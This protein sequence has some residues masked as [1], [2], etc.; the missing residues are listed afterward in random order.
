MK[1][2][3]TTMF[4]TKVGFEEISE[5]QL[6]LCL[7]DQTILGNVQDIMASL[8]YPIYKSQ[9]RRLQNMIPGCSGSFLAMILLPYEQLLYSLC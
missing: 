6:K 2:K 4:E 8:L 5:L 7:N 3:H 9:Q 1:K